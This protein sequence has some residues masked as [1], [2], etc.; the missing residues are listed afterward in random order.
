M[1]YE[2]ANDANSRLANTLVSLKT[3]EPFYI[4]GCETAT[5]AVG[6]N[7]VT[8]KKETR[9]LDEVNLVPVKLGYVFTGETVAYVMRKPT[10]K[11]QQG[12]N[13]HNIVVSTLKK[14]E[15]EGRPRPRY[16]FDLAGQ[17]ICQTILGKYPDVGTAFQKVRSGEKEAMAFSRE[18]AVGTDGVDIIVYHK[19]SVVGFVTNTSVKLLP[20]YAFLKESLEESFHEKVPV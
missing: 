13:R 20:E 17:E 12:L 16:E 2:T 4:M 18:W 15:G 10:R 14:D 3:G 9:S 1:R 8:K 6:K 11:Y 5:S 19:A 7:L